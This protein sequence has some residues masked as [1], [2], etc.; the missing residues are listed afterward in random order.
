MAD[1]TSELLTTIAD[2]IRTLGVR[3]D[4]VEKRMDDDKAKRDAE[5]EEER[6]KADRRRMDD[7]RKR[8]DAF[9]FSARRDDDDDDKFKDRRDNEETELAKAGEEAGEEPGKAREM[10]AD[11]RKKADDDDAKR[12]KDDDDAKKRRDDA[13]GRMD[14]HAFSKR[15]DD[16]DDAKFKARRDAE[17]AELA[18]SMEESGE[19]K[20]DAKMH[21]AD[22]RKKADDDDDDDDDDR[23]RH[24]SSVRT[25]LEAL[26]RNRARSDDELNQLAE[27]QHEWETV[28]QAHGERAHRPLD[29]E[30]VI[31]YDRRHARRFQKFSKRW[32]DVDL[33]T[34]DPAVLK[35]A[36]PE[37][38]AD[39]VAAAYSGE[40]MTATAGL[41][42]IV[43]MDRTGRNISE[44]VGPVSAT[45]APFQLPRMRVRGGRINT[46]PNAY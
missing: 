26:E 14:A 10:A 33:A 36:T 39:A 35:I 25:R 11:K 28:A 9:K 5:M 3:M 24:D 43:R 34:L 29:G 4:G 23:K 7:A 18:K 16:D 37:I 32:K 2:G 44:F 8:M 12:R 19:S 6:G 45:L 41:R 17:E 21:A 46:Q 42:E 40:G 38:R 31:T 20:E 1:S 30:A 27:R 15:M 22:R 13:K